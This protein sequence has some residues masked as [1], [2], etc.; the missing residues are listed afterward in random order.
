MHSLPH[1][2]KTMHLFFL[3]ALRGFHSVPFFKQF[4]ADTKHKATL[5]FVQYT[6]VFTLWPEI[7][8]RAHILLP[9]VASDPK[10]SGQH[11]SSS[12]ADGAEVSWS[13]DVDGSVS[14]DALDGMTIPTSS[15]TTSVSRNSF[16]VRGVFFWN[17]N[18]YWWRIKL[19]TTAMSTKWEKNVLYHF[20]VL[21]RTL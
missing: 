14:S 13:H 1:L 19:F 9:L 20:L 12:T 2:T 7:L 5:H 6:G 18:R 4:L 11:S 16:W 15:A 3:I 17:F 21:C 8:H 10:Y